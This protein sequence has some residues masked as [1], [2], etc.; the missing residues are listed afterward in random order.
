MKMNKI[1]LII[2]AV[3]ASSALFAQSF[4][5]AKKKLKTVYQNHMI[6]FYSGCEIRSRGKKLIPVLSTCGYKVRK[7]ER[8]ANRIEWEHVMPA[9]DFGRQMKCWRDGGRKNCK[10]NLKFKAMEGDMHNLVPAIGEINGDRSNYKFAMLQGEGEKYGA[11]DF[12]IDFKNKRV[13]PRDSVKGDIARIYFYMR[14]NYKIRLSKQQSRM[15]QAWSKSDP[16][17]EWEKEKNR[18]I[19]AI[20]GNRNNYVEKIETIRKAS[21]NEKHG[22][23]G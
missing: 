14:D 4:G 16:I 10:K 12:E 8:R 22:R 2:L 5:S 3:V 19:F 23:L 9:Y 11:V 13:E 15:F 17:D 21:S 7:Q 1:L 6:A 18:L 20:Q